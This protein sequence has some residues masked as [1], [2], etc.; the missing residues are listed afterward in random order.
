MCLLKGRSMSKV[1]NKNIRT[2]STRV[3]FLLKKILWLTSFWCF[4]YRLW[5]HFTT[6]FSVSMV[7]F[8]QVNA[9]WDASFLHHL[10]TSENLSFFNVFLGTIERENW[11]AM[12]QVNFFATQQWFIFE[13]IYRMLLFHGFIQF[14]IKGSEM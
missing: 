12:G 10:N 3:S 6:S 7:D 2:T 5:T 8:E 9:I 13:N 1:N 4:Y 14:Y 11:P